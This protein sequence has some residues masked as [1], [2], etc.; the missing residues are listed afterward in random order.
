MNTPLLSKNQRDM[1]SQ[2]TWLTPCNEGQAQRP[3]ADSRVGAVREL[4][5]KLPASFPHYLSTVERL[6]DFY[7]AFLFLL[8]IIENGPHCI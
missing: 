2:Q 4:G 3:S 6:E 7:K 5:A 8:H 1:R